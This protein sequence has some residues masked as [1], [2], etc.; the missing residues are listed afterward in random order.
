MTCI[1]IPYIASH[2]SRPQMQHKGDLTSTYEG[3]V[4]GEGGGEGGGGGG[5]SDATW[6]AGCETLERQREGLQV[7]T[8][9]VM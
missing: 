2:Y 9:I 4:T 3:A 8:E 1:L 5:G 7:L 6:E